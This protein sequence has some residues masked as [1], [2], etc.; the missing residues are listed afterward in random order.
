[1]DCVRYLRIFLVLMASIGMVSCSSDGD[2]IDGS[3]EKPKLPSITGI[4]AVGSPIINAKLVLKSRKGKLITTKTK[5]DG[6]YDIDVAGFEY[7]FIMQVE[8][9]GGEYLLS[10]ATSAGTAN[11]HPLTDLI[12]RNWFQSN[13][14]DVSG[15]FD[16]ET[17]LTIQP[18]SKQISDIESVVEEIAK[19]SFSDFEIPENFDLI[20]TPFEADGTGFDHYLDNAK[21]TI[22]QNQ[23]NVVIVHPVTKI[24]N[25]L[26]VNLA[27]GTNLTEVD[28]MPPTDPNNIRSFAINE[29]ETLTI[30]EPGTDNIAVSGYYV[31]RNED[32]IATTAFPF[33]SD[34]NLSSNTD[35]CYA[36]EAF[37]AAGNKS[38]RVALTPCIQTSSEVDSVPP[39]IPTSLLV[40][41]SLHNAIELQWAQSD[42]NDVAGFKIYQGFSGSEKVE[43]ANVTTSQHTVYGLLSNTLYC[44]EVSAYD[45]A[46]NE[47]ERSDEVC[48]KSRENISQSPKGD[49]SISLSNSLFHTS[50]NTAVVPVIVNRIGNA[51][52]EISIDFTVE[53][54]TAD[55]GADFAGQSGS[56]VWLVNETQPKTIYVHVKSDL[57]QES[58]ETVKVSLMSPSINTQLGEHASALVEIS[59]ASCDGILD[60]HISVDTTIS[61]CTVVTRNIFIGDGA[62][63]TVEPGVSLIF[64]NGAGFTVQQD[65]A[66]TAIG[67]LV[68]PILF[69]SEQRTPGYWDG[70]EFVFSNNIKNDLDFVT[71]EYGGGGGNGEGANVVLN[72]SQGLP[73]RLKISNSHL[74]HSLDYGFNFDAGAIVDE[75]SNNVI[76][77][78]RI[79]GKVHANVTGKLT[80]SSSYS[81]NTIDEIEVEFGN[82]DDDQTWSAIDVPYTLDSTSIYADLTI[83][84]G[85]TLAFRA[86]GR[87]N[88]TQDGSLKAIGTAEKKILF[89]GEQPTRGYWDGI[90]FVFSNNVNNILDHVVVE[91]AGGGTYEGNVTM[92]G[93]EAN[94]QRLQISNTILRESLG[95]GFVFDEGSILDKFEKNTAALNK[96]GPGQLPANIVGVLDG[97]SQ[98]VGNDA[99]FIFVENDNV[100]ASQTWATI[101]VPFSL[102]SFSIYGHLTIAAGNTLLFNSAARIN[103]TQE[104]SL[105]AIGAEQNPITF[106]GAQEMPGYWGGIQFT[107]SN[108]VSNHFDYV[109]VDYAGQINTGEGNVILN[110]SSTRPSSLIITNSRLQN[111]STYG[112]WLNEYV[113]LNTDYLTSNNFLNNAAGDVRLP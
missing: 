107:F 88:V 62:T 68:Q 38:G 104:G 31:F 11:I 92:F 18:T 36:V 46:G 58:V 54:G 27:V 75:F 43:V 21:V 97:E 77:N 85:A 34:K 108:N 78:N 82:V 101:D 112:L 74:A 23:I 83:E 53:S 113:N 12:I 13:D 95:Y 32:L 1:M 60:E 84:A 57:L 98:Y 105:T 73:Q 44:F 47:S 109:T 6:S 80:S 86:G 3:G 103:V 9:P 33:F 102:D 25:F 2:G 70:V 19:F 40:L 7:P 66:L 4:A 100:D 96:K 22:V 48:E 30:W 29:S 26:I 52:E 89:T 69:T 63:L 51:L 50:E 110:G 71:I 93:S 67:S 55:I 106:S 99:D 14:L 35:Y 17:A 61:N 49:S 5:S 41:E 45:A 94:P 90:D 28:N 81:G 8:K 42:I 111:S 24:E 91:Y 20:R 65:G 10:V 39:A 16:N 59:D 79:S 37:D 72:G 56:L 87:I 76:T 15:I 64:Q